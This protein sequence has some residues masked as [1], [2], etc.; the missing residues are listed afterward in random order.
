[1]ENKI[2]IAEIL[3]DCPK[4]MKL[5]SPLCG[6]C[7]LYDVNDYNIR[8]STP[9]KDTLICLYHDGRYCANGE[10]MLFPKGKTTW[11]GFQ[12]PFVDGDILATK[13]GLF[14]GIVKIENGVQ[15][16]AYVAINGINDLSRNI[17]YRFE[18]LATEE[19][20]Q[21]LFQSIKD[22]GYK[23]NSKTKTLEK[24]IEPKFKVGDKVKK[25]KDYISG[26][27]TDI[28]D[29]SFKVTYDGGG[30]SYVQFH[31]QDDWELVKDNI[32]PK[33]KVG[34]R[35]IKRDSIVNSWIVSSVS[36]EY[37]GLQLPNRSDGI[38]V[39]P[40]VEQDDYELVSDIEPKFKKGDKIKHRLTGEVYIVLFV[41][42]NGYGG[43]VYDVA[44]TN[45]IGKSI[46]I[47]EQD[48]YELV[49]NKFDINTL[50]PFDKVLVR[51][52][53]SYWRIQFFEKINK[54]N[55]NYAFGC[56]NGNNYKQCIPYEGNEHLY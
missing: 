45:E 37:Y 35:I 30:C 46:D 39:L 25:N 49:P 19:E 53:N 42:S 21:K 8:I 26:I 27:V 17:S 47:K 14:I 22:N 50:K 56:M 28:F 33:F 24:L 6:E 16:S 4:G 34:D 23:W 43:G 48:N 18:R 7:T 2:N 15:Q 3:K 52:N 55:K 29:D 5:Y 11:E 54:K 13:N 1:M 9:N 32:K 40:I 31:Y 41:L 20:K 10:I 44:V 51:V 36:S 12:R 38:G